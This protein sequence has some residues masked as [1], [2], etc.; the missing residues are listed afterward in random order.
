MN[1]EHYELQIQR[2]DILSQSLKQ[3]VQVQLK[4]GKDL[5]KLPLKIHFNNEPGIDVGG[6]RKEYFQLIMR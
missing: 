6:V 3:I 5:L 2:E 4:Q 1:A